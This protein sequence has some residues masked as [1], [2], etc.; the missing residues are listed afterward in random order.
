MLLLC[1]TL[2]GGLRVPSLPPPLSLSLSLSLSL[3]DRGGGG[4][5]DEGTEARQA[6]GQQPT[7]TARRK[8]G[9]RRPAVRDERGKGGKRNNN[10]D[11][12][13]KL[14]VYC[15]RTGVF[16]YSCRRAVV[17]SPSHRPVERCV[18]RL[19]GWIG[20]GGGGVQRNG[21]GVAFDSGVF[22]CSC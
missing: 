6:T 2:G 8:E 12:N 17:A 11:G 4:G 21:M 5:G 13:E 7:A 22:G 15:T 14:E 3:C 9:R 18:V 20:P 19:V 1:L 16:L 10:E